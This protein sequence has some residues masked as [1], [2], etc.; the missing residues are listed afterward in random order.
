MKFEKDHRTNA[1][2]VGLLSLALFGCNFT[3]AYS[4]SPQTIS[5]DPAIDPPA[6]ATPPP[7]LPASKSTSPTEITPQP[8]TP[9][10]TATSEITPTSSLTQ[11]PTASA[12]GVT[13]SRTSSRTA[14]S[15][16]TSSLTATRNSYAYSDLYHRLGHPIPNWQPHPGHDRHAHL[17]SHCVQES[18]RH[19][20]RNS[21]VGHF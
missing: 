3:G 12:T 2:L 6:S 21:P 1:V 9:S 19:V 7:S 17:D 20:D 16:P 11:T 13:P 14:G 10:L 18:Y 15:S 8:G 4:L 5:S